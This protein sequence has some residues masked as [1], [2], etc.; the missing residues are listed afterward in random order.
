MKFLTSFF[1]FLA[2]FLGPNNARASNIEVTPEVS[3][4]DQDTKIVV[5][6]LSPNEIV[7]MKAEAI[8]ENNTCWLSFAS[9]QANE[10]GIV[11]LSKQS[12]L[13]V[14]Y[15]GM[16]SMGLLWS[17][18]SKEGPSAS[19]LVKKDQ[20]SIR[21]KVFRDKQEIA[22]K[23][24]VR[25]LKAPTV[26][27]I[28]IR[29]NGLVGVLFVPPS[30][31]P[32]PVIITLSGSNGGISEKVSGLLAAHGFAVFALGYFGVD[33]L[34]PFLRDIPLE[35]FA[36]AFSWLKTRPDIDGSRIGIFG[37]S[38]GGELALILGSWFPESI[39]AIAANVPSSVIYGGSDGKNIGN[40][41]TFHGKPIGPCAHEIFP[42]SF[43]DLG[44]DPEHPFKE[45]PGF[46]EGMK[47]KE[48]FAA[49]AI[50]VEKIRASLLLTSGGDDQMWP[51]GIYSFQI[52]ERLREYGSTIYWQHL[53]YPKAG[54][55]IGYPPLPESSNIY[56]HPIAKRWFDLGGSVA[57]NRYA[58][59]DA[60]KKILT[61]F[62]K[63]LK[64][65]GK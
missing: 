48:V 7:Y 42:P 57:D 31:K 2:T 11:D 41:W 8:D 10:E 15:Q 27:K 34:P 28:S 55:G 16:D 3:L 49:A 12:P 5:Q 45:T 58:S 40:A 1:L 33:G 24:I 39:Q 30:E 26:K 56:Y 60:W 50:P 46:L 54:H 25:L 35:Y 51:S 20:F 22:S 6:Y 14:T 21:L 9:F 65:G 64:N 29:E 38:R 23:E 47:E 19:F 52:E 36:T 37:G 53:H 17:M 32:L 43:E 61:F 63:A 4:L 62:E 13:E 18:Q 59:Q 44:K